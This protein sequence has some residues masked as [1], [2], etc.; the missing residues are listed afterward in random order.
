MVRPRLESKATH[1]GVGLVGWG[2]WVSNGVG[3]LLVFRVWVWVSG[4]GWV[5]N[6]KTPISLPRS[7]N[8]TAKKSNVLHLFDFLATGLRVNF[9]LTGQKSLIFAMTRLTLSRKV[10]Y[11]SH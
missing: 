2:A 4:R 7:L 6:V 11:R 3:S 5:S 8:F 9:S 1:N 10:K